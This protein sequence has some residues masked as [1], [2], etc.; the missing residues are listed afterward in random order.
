VPDLNAFASCSND[1]T[2][3]LWSFDGTHMMDL[4]G[5]NGFIFAIDTLETGEIVSGGDDCTVKVWKDGACK[6]T[7]QMPRSVWCI[8]HNKFGDLIVGCEDKTIRLFTRDTKRQEKGQ[9]LEEYETS[10]KEGVKQAPMPEVE[11]L[12]EFSTDVKGKMEGANGGEI[13]VFR[14]QGKAKAYMWKAEE[15]TWEEIGEVV[16]PTAANREEAEPAGSISMGV[17][18]TK[19]YGG[20]ALF[21][22]G[23]YDHVFD[24][25]LGDGIMRKLPFNNGANFLEAADKFCTREGLSR[26]NVEQ[27][28]GFLRT[29]AKPFRTRD[30]DGSDAS[31][32]EKASK[33]GPKPSVIPFQ[34]SIFYDAVKIEAPRKKILEFNEELKVLDEK[35]LIYYDQAC[36]VL[37]QP[38]YF[39]SSDVGPAQI[40]VIKKLLSEFPSDKLFP[41]FDLYRIFLMHPCSSILKHV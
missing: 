32:A 30:F 37:G 8:T 13:K 14:D 12:L 23:E 39:H 4:K 1:E 15:R 40:H 31:K 24:V 21:A 25:E 27:I 41:V 26:G 6:Q 38:Q 34:S 17:Q 33:W 20:D 36:K 35:D 2:I 29:H 10:C 19:Q 3:K 7:I 9:E 22:A 5:H 28:V 11:K 16:D 18:G